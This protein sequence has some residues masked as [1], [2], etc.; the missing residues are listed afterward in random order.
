[1]LLPFVSAASLFLATK[2]ALGDN[3]K[4]IFIPLTMSKAVPQQPYTR[5]DP[6]VH[7]YTTFSQDYELQREVQSE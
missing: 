1:M 3:D 7:T 6:V 2:L 5:E 4:T